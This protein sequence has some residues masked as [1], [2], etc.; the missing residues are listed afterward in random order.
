MLNFNIVVLWVEAISD[1]TL[2]GGENFRELYTK[3]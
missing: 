3:N 1:L 2:G